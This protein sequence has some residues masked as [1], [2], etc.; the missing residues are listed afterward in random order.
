MQSIFLV[1]IGMLIFIGG[2]LLL[3]SKKT[4][5]DHIVIIW[6]VLAIFSQ[7]GFYYVAIG[8]Y[9]E[10]LRFSQFVFSTLLL[11]APMLYFYVQAQLDPHFTFNSKKLLHL[12]P[13]FIFYL[14]HIPEFSQNV[15]LSVC[16]NHFG[17]YLS[18]KPCSIV[19]NF[20]KMILNT[21]YLMLTFFVYR[22]LYKSTNKLKEKEK[23][24][25]VWIKILLYA[26]FSLNIFIIFYRLLEVGQIHIFPENL[27]LMNIVISANIIV[28]SFIGSNFLGILDSLK[29]INK[30]FVYINIKTS[31]Y[32]KNKI[33][34]EDLIPMEDC[35]SEFGLSEETIQKYSIKLKKFM[36]EKKPFLEPQL[37]RVK[38]AEV[39]EIPS[40]HLAYIIKLKYN[41]TFN[42]FINTYRLELLLEMLDDQKY[43][44]YT[45]LALAYECGFNSKSTFNRFFKNHLGKTPSEI[46]KLRQQDMEIRLAG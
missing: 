2:S 30:F 40:H 46:L 4:T 10:H 24:R 35:H 27:F 43:A 3:K 36:T 11:H 15:G 14:L 26:T 21:F 29:L 45:L 19:Y 12:T 28:F 23:I 31:F 42:D 9:K 7:L 8:E 34:E 25:F 16:A 33:C 22:D 41:Q 20:S 44:N 6:T 13:L 37:T 39:L 5:S 32:L 17:C 18:N 1:C 38:L